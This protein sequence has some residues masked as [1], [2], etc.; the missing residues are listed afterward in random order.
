LQYQKQAE[1]LIKANTRKGEDFGYEIQ[2]YQQFDFDFIRKNAT[3]RGLSLLSFQADYISYNSVIITSEYITFIAA[4]P[5]NIVKI[6]RENGK[7]YVTSKLS[8][9]SEKLTLVEAICLKMIAK[10]RMPNLL[11]E[12]FSGRILEKQKEWM[13]NFGLSENKAF[14]EYFYYSFYAER[15]LLYLPMKKAEGLVPVTEI[16]GHN[17][18]DLFRNLNNNRLV[19]DKLQQKTEL[20]ELGF[21]VTKGYHENNQYWNKY[22]DFY[23][24]DDEDNDHYEIVPIVGKTAKNNPSVFASHIDEYDVE[25]DQQF[26]VS[27]CENTV[28]LLTVIKE[29]DNN[30]DNYFHLMKKASDCLLHEKLVFGLAKN[31]SKIRKKNLIEITLSPEQLDVVF[32]LSKNQ[33]F[34]TLYLKLKKGTELRKRKNLGSKP[35]DHYFYVDGNIYYFAKTEKV[36]QMIAQFPE[37]V[38]MVA[39]HKD[40]FFKNVVEPVSKNFAVQFKNNTFKTESIELD[41]QKKQVFLSEQDQYVVFTPCVEYENNVSAILNTN[42]QYPCL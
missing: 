6:Y 16:K 19:L 17:M 20:R 38:K 42:R 2:G 12:V 14:H 18:N 24:E 31:A 27:K 36:A 15:G 21:V 40:E 30:N 8:A 39:S 23:E 3:P 10:S 28:T 32:E 13:R 4:H 26:I 29:M 35:D 9:N 1:I 7:V 5:E 22:D 34:F 33:E 25:T 11:D 37:K 41:F